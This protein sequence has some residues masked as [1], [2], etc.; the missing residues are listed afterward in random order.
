MAA[1]C[2][3][4]ASSPAARR[5]ISRASSASASAS[6]LP[7]RQSGP[8]GPPQASS[9]RLLAGSALARSASPLPSASWFAASQSASH[10]RNRAPMPLTAASRGGASPD[11]EAAGACRC[12]RCFEGCKRGLGPLTSSAFGHRRSKCRA[13]L[14]SSTPC[15]TLCSRSRE[16]R[17]D[18]VRASTAARSVSC[19][20]GLMG[21]AS[22]SSVVRLRAGAR[23]TWFELPIST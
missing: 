14:P 5:A 11:A 2:R 16:A 12:A 22:A 6:R 9:C 10:R 21:K 18:V 19:S 4:E 1:D 7:A 8:F 15:A 3:P 13:A 23:W 20:D 17:H